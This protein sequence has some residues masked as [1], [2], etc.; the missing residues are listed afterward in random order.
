M[1]PSVE[2]TILTELA[3]VRQELREMR[4]AI[5]GDPTD[6]TRPGIITRLDRLEQQMAGVVWV[7]RSVVG[8]VLTIVV[9]A[10]LGFTLG[11]V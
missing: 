6:T 11:R 5:S 10:V 3:A 2:Q 9:G 4:L 8:A 7:T 1:I